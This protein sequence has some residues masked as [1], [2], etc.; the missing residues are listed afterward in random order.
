MIWKEAV[1]TYFKVLASILMNT[2]KKKKEKQD[3]R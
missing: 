3:C 1:V 2:V